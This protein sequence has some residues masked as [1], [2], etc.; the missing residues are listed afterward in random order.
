M[1]MGGGAR[2]GDGAGI[3][4]GDMGGCQVPGLLAL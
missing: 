1:G 4:A 3:M 2:V